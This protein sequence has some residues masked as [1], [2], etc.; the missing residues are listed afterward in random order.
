MWISV[1]TRRCSI[2][3]KMRSRLEQKVRT[4]F[5]RDSDKIASTVVYLTKANPGR[6][7]VE[8]TARIVLWSSTLGQIA[9]NDAGPTMRSAVGRAARRAR[10]V[11]RQYAKRRI[12]TN[13]L[14]RHFKAL[15]ETLQH[16]DTL[17][18]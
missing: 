3:Q 15:D 11:V 14:A 13:R 10:Q 8:Y 12:T 2:S 4:I 7:D 16:P 17:A 18:R 1:R 5:A 9:V 6:D